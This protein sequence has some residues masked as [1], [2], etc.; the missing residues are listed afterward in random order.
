VRRSEAKPSR[1]DVEAPEVNERVLVVNADDFGRSPGVNAGVI[2]CHALGIVTSASLMVR[3]PD[4]EEAAAYARDRSLGVGLH[5]DLGEW[6]YR[7]GEWRQLYQVLVEESSDAVAAELGRQLERFE[8]LVGRPPDH[9]DSHQ[10][11]HREEPIRG[12]MLA[13]GQRLG[14]PVREGSPT[15]AY[16]GVFYGQGAHGTPLPEAI[17]VEALVAAIESLPP[18]V[19]ELACHPA[20]VDDHESMYGA[21][22]LI[23]AEAL[24]D[25]RVRA[26]VDR[27]GVVLESFAG[28]ARRLA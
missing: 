22:R 10:H 24:C 1:D 7:T 11:V 5:L 23:E 3:W 25:P 17:T 19:T 14:I 26:A 27:S 15:I 8:R 4:C 12:A 20:A 2:R 6:E 21:E 9:L 18:G 13:A 28:A 16:S